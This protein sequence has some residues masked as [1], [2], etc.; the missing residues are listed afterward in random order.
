MNDETVV[1]DSTLQHLETATGAVS[2]STVEYRVQGN[3]NSQ[4]STTMPAF[5][6]VG[7]YIIEARAIN[8]NY[9]T[10]YT[11][12]TLNINKR[13]VVIT[14]SSR[15]TTYDGGVQ[16]VSGYS[17]QRQDDEN[18]VGLVTGQRVRGVTASASGT[19]PYPPAGWTHSPQA[20]IPRKQCS[21]C[22]ALSPSGFSGFRW[23]TSSPSCNQ[24]V[25]ESECAGR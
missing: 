9:E 12:A 10:S 14:G 1:Y 2:G 11:T 7:T 22:D 3:P 17:V 13:P 4:W 25:P 24:S 15:T 19:N 16:S 21:K 6:E 20:H 23:N 8:D 18:N 5:T